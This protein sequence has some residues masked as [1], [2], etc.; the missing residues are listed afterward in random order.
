MCELYDRQCMAVLLIFILDHDMCQLWSFMIE[1]LYD[2]YDGDDDDDDDNDDFNVTK[3]L[4]PN[5]LL[6]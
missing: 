2:D 5:S 4:V 6:S 3:S 1:A